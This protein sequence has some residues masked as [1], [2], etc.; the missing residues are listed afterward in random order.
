MLLFRYVVPEEAAK[1]AKSNYSAGNWRNWPLLVPRLLGG[2]VARGK[3]LAPNFSSPVKSDGSDF[4]YLCD[5]I[6]VPQGPNYILSKRMQQWR[7]MVARQ[8]GHTASFNVAPATATLSVLKNRQFAWAYDGMSYFDRQV[9]ASV[10][11]RSFSA[12]FRSVEVF[13]EETSNSVMT[14]LL[15]NDLTNP[16]SAANPK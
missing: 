11:L 9:G 5:A 2:L 15:L 6:T 12:S 7:C 10:C 4:F 16:S 3:F 13:Q 1:A 14:A 8:A